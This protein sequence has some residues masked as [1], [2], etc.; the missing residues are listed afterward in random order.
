MTLRFI[1]HILA[2]FL[3]ALVWADV[4][5]VRSKASAMIQPTQL[6]SR[7]RKR[8]GLAEMFIFIGVFGLGLWQW[9]PLMKA[10]PAPI[11]HTKLGLAVIFLLLAKVRMLRE[12]KRGVQVAMTR[13]MGLIVLVNFILGAYWRS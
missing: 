2:T 13:I 7:W 12:R 9:W 8:V 6:V 5:F 1:H 11:F 3:C 10:Y 4:F